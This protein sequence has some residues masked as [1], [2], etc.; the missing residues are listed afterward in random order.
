MFYARALPCPWCEP[1]WW[2]TCRLVLPLLGGQGVLPMG[3]HVRCL[4][5]GVFS[6][7]GVP[8]MHGMGGMSVSR[9]LWE[10]SHTLRAAYVARTTCMILYCPCSLSKN[11]RHSIGRFLTYAPFFKS[12]PPNNLIGGS[13]YSTVDSAAETWWMSRCLLHR[14]GAPPRVA[15]VG[16]QLA[17]L[18]RP[19]E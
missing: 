10:Y 15:F 8:C 18:G 1:T 17:G 5:R 3:G 7:A 16:C 2:W 6:L 12:N 11:F 9:C 13:R 4:M 14:P 19:L